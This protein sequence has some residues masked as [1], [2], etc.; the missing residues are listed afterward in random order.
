MQ[1]LKDTTTLRI[2]QIYVI[3]HHHKPTINE[4]KLIKFGAMSAI[5]LL[6]LASG[7]SSNNNNSTESANADSVAEAAKADSIANAD[8]I[9]K[10]LEQ[11][12]A[13]SIA[14]AD[15]VAKAKETESKAMDAK[16]DKIVAK[17]NKC[18]DAVQGL[19]NDGIPST[20][21]MAFR[22]LSNLDV[23]DAEYNKIKGQLTEEQKAR[24]EAVRKKF[25]QVNA[26]FN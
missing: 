21:S 11:A 5:A 26:K 23:P 6:M 18:I 12:K 20:S 25:D 1:A 3:L 8:S 7:C 16:V 19:I 13:D 2:I 22:V 9:A 10:V 15:S 14:A 17:Y 4:M 24:I